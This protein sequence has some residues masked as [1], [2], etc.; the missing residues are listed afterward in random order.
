MGYAG[1]SADTTSWGGAAPR[2]P[3]RMAP[4]YDVPRAPPATG[5]P[6]SFA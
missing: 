1:G 4:D 2:P 3:P 5:Y 6:G